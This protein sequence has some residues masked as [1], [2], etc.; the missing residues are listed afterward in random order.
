MQIQLGPTEFLKEVS[1]TYR[2][3]VVSSLKFVTNL[4]T[5][6]PY[7][8]TLDGTPFKATAPANSSI[9]GF[10]AVTGRYMDKIGVYVL[11]P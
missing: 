3:K 2:S 4:K 11:G 10:F 8:T 1:G 9:V 7:G 6:G 5:Y